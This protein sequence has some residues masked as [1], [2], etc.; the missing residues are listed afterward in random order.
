MISSET[1]T[2]P[3]DLDAVRLSIM[4]LKDFLSTNTGRLKS[5]LDQ[6]LPTTNQSTSMLGLNFPCH[7]IRT[8]YQSIHN[9]YFVPRDQ[10][11]L[12]SHQL[13]LRTTTTR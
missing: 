6:I 9:S 12:S 11:V 10:G 4:C 1:E 7:E 3:I 8:C 5:P 13:R 2:D